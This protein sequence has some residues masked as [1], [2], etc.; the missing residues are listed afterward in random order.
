MDLLYRWGREHIEHK[1]ED[2]P[3]NEFYTEAEV[4]AFFEG[5]RIEEADREHHRL[6]P[7][8]RRGLKAVLYTYVLKP[9]YN[10]IPEG[11]ALRLAYKYSITA[12][13]I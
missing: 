8:A 10:L 6:L 5:F 1:D 3:V 7:V 9:V 2:P 11:L 13:K 12:T 4:R